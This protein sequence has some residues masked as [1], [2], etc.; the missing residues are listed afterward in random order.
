MRKKATSFNRV[1]RKPRLFRNHQNNN[2]NN[3]N[4][5]GQYAIFDF[6]GCVH[7]VCAVSVSVSVC[8]CVCLLTIHRTAQAREMHVNEHA[9]WIYCCCSAHAAAVVVFFVV[10]GKNLLAQAGK[11]ID[12]EEVIERLRMTNLRNWSGCCRPRFVKDVRVQ[13]I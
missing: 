3:S 4:Y 2:N 7:C 11:E 5:Y 1:C 12:R 9:C 6:F 8:V 10:Q 13:A